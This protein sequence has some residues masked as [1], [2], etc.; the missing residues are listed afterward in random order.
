MSHGI[1]IRTISI[2]LLILLLFC[3][4]CRK[5]VSEINES[6][7]NVSSYPQRIVVFPLF[8]EEILLDLI[9]PERIVY[10]GHQY[11]EGGEDYSP[12]MKLAKLIPGSEWQ[13]TDE[14][15]IIALQPDLIVLHED[16]KEAYMSGIL[17][18]ELEKTSVSVIFV[19]HP[20]TIKDVEENIL[21]LG[22]TVGV[23]TKASDMV[24]QLKNS[25]QKSLNT[26]L[27]LDRNTP[28]K[29]LYYNTWQES[30][31]IIAQLCMFDCL[32]YDDYVLLDDSQISEWNPDYIFF[33]PARVDSDGT[34]L[35]INDSSTIM[36]NIT[37]NSLLSDTKAI[38]NGNVYPLY[39][40]SS[41][42]I[43]KNIEEVIQ[44]LNLNSSNQDD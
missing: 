17:Y 4:L 21:L 25:I 11:I 41:H 38:R 34:L 31:P 9:G 33:K 16:M 3:V 36:K 32:Y 40:H 42:Y 39:L 7:S 15:E 14:E 26:F 13:N 30:F 5:G 8:A 6:E 43:V 27:R 1:T 18:P 12:T 37:N 44:L 35:D 24:Y 10:I 28:A 20:R 2:L 23:P 29:V 22:E 19:K